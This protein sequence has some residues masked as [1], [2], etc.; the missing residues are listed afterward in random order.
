[1]IDQKPF[2]HCNCQGGSPGLVIMGDNSCLKGHGFKSQRHILDGHFSHWFVVK[3][4]LFEKAE[5]KQKEAEGG[6]I[7]AKFA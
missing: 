4:V 3:I 1:M 2:K 7:T 6:I 5:N